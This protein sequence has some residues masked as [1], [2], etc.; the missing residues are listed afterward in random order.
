MLARDAKEADPRIPQDGPFAG[1]VR[2]RGNHAN[3]STG[4]G[5]PPLA[6]ELMLFSDAHG[7]T[8]Y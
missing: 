1:V 3:S 7:F 5:T 2:I 4:T 6:P 8:S